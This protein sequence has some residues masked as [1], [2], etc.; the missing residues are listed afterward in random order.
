MHFT[1]NPL[2][3]LIL[4]F[5]LVTKCT[6]PFLPKHT[7]HSP[8]SFSASQRPRTTLSGDGVSEKSPRNSTLASLVYRNKPVL[9]QVSC[10]RTPEVLR[11]LEEL[12]IT[13]HHVAPG[14]LAGVPAQ[15]EPILT[16]YMCIIGAERCFECPGDEKRSRSHLRFSAKPALRRRGVGA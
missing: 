6:C 8:S 9:R 4:Y 15:W 16:R 11:M 1:V 10:V 13:R 12:H 3:S 2:S 5:Q 14:I 7:S